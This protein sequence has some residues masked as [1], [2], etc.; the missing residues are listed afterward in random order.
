MSYT[1]KLP[2]AGIRTCII[3]WIGGEAAK[4]TCNAGLE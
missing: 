1:E 2:S 3:I 4:C